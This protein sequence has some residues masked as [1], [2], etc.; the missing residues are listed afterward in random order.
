VNHDGHIDRLLEKVAGQSKK[1]CIDEPVGTRKSRIIQEYE[2]RLQNRWKQAN[3]RG[4]CLQWLRYVT[5]YA[6]RRYTPVDLSNGLGSCIESKIGYSTKVK[7]ED[8]DQVFVYVASA[9]DSLM[10]SNNRNHITNHAANLRKCAKHQG[11]H[12]TDFVSSVV[13]EASF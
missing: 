12:N 9:L 3:E 4:N 2:H 7:A 5:Q 1:I 8:S 13:A 6:E 10:I 11:S